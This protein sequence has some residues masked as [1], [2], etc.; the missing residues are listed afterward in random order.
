MLYIAWRLTIFPDLEQTVLQPPQAAAVLNDRIRL[1]NKIN[2]DVADWLQ[3]GS[4]FLIQD[5]L[6]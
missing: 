1:I 2:A 4:G 3:V 5:Y 6:N